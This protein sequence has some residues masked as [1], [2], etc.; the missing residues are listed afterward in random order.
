MPVLDKINK[1]SFFAGL[2]SLNDMYGL[3]EVSSP[4]LWFL[5]ILA[6]IE[7]T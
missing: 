2:G 1:R 6:C 3:P 5:A 7:I 4:A